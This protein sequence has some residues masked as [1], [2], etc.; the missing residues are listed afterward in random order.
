MKAEKHINSTAGKFT[1]LRQI[2]SLIPTH[3]VGRLVGKHNSKDDA[4][5]FSHW[6]H[7][8]SLIYSKLTHAFGL[9]N[10]C[11][12][13]GLYSGPLASIRGATP[14]KRNTLSHANRVR[15]AA[16]AEDLFW[17]ALKHLREQSPGFGRRRLPGKLRQFK[18]T[19]HLLDSTV[20][21]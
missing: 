18:R 5:T 9:N 10:V 13:L 16:I 4:R 11:D 8:V 20:V 2:C 12:A 1:V 15:P 21:E 17:G 14:P 3:L 19:I 6:S 7:V